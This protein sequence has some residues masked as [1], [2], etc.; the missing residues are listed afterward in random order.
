MVRLGKNKMR[1]TRY[2]CDRGKGEGGGQDDESGEQEGDSGKSGESEKSSKSEKSGDP[3]KPGDSE[4]SG[5][6]GKEAEKKVIVSGTEA[7]N[8]EVKVAAKVT[9]SV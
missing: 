9:G 1:Y 8:S 7:S 5:D 6:T 3:E 2:E 4:K